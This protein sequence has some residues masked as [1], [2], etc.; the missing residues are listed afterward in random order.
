MKKTR[1]TLLALILPLIAFADVEPLQNIS[2]LTLSAQA[3]IQKPADELQINIGIVTIKDSAEK[4][5]QENSQK[6]NAVIKNL[7][8]A[9]LTSK[10]YET[11]H[12]SINPTYTPYPKDPPADWKPSINGYEVNNTVFIHTSAI[13]S[14]GKIIDAANQA[15]ANNISNIRFVLNDKNAYW[16]EAIALATANAISD[17]QAMAKAANQKLVRIVSISLD[18]DSNITPRSNTL[19]AAKAMSYESAPPI[20]AGDV[21]IKANVTITYEIAP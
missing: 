13:D 4:A 10:D 11:G 16:Q 6:M 17:A 21:S 8:A 5:L 1:F 18:N 12:F 14:A 15:G 9:G 19:F 2:K 20:E 7:A 3:T